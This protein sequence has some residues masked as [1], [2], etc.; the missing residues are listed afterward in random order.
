M[1][2]S[3]N[4]LRMESARQGRI[5]LPG[6]KSTRLRD[7]LAKRRRSELRCVAEKNR[8]IDFSWRNALITSSALSH[9]RAASRISRRNRKISLRRQ[10][11]PNSFVA[12]ALKNWKCDL[13]H[14][15]RRFNMKKWAPFRRWIPPESY[16]VEEQSHRSAIC[17]LWGE[18]KVTHQIE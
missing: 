4:L 5:L 12:N 2:W 11:R 13:C 8:L 9:G 14:V 1:D 15:R 18:K 7:E 17:I 6:D 10:K 16:L 3:A